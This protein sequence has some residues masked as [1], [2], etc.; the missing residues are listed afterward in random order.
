MDSRKDF[1]GIER[2]VHERRM[3]ERADSLQ[4]ENPEDT[5]AW[6]LRP[7]LATANNRSDQDTLGLL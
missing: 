6:C 2:R 1:S 7:D 5:Q 3:V 4:R